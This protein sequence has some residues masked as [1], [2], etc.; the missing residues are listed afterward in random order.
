MF[1]LTRPSFRVV[2]SLVY[3]VITRVLCSVPPPAN[4]SLN[5]HNFK[6]VLYWN[7]SEPSLQPTF[8][9]SVRTYERSTPLSVRT[10]EH[11]LDISSYTQDVEDAYFV[12]VMAELNES[13][14]PSSRVFTQ[15]TYGEFPSRIK[16]L[17]DFPPLNISVRSRTFE[18]EFY[19]PSYIYGIERLNDTFTYTVEYNEIESTTYSCFVNDWICTEKM[20]LPESLYGSCMTVH[21]GGSIKGLYTKTSRNVCSDGLDP[22]EKD[23]AT[24]ITALVCS[25]IVLVLVILLGGLLYKKLT[26]IKSQSS[27]F[28][29]LLS[30]VKSDHVV[31][32][33]EN[34]PLSEVMSVSNTP[35]LDTS[36]DL[37]SPTIISP[38][39]MTHGLI[40]SHLDMEAPG[41]QEPEDVMEEADSE[42]AQSCTGYDCGKFPVI[43]SPEDTVD[44]YG[45]R[46]N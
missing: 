21:F 39:S 29:K 23:W 31:I 14:K 4:L 15:F 36:E 3:S 8:N 42:D 18:I 1:Q 41:S 16:C 26:H 2:L 38:T 37:S 17:M 45:P 24:L 33:P 30:M 19:H 34:P 32:E 43:M 7:Y 35:L 22:D 27:V 13:A 28:S 10:S 9:V 12:S 6:N 44:A 5:C 11:Y 40:D 20:H 25:G 46:Q